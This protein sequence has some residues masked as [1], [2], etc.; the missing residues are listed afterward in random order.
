VCCLL[1]G[2][3]CVEFWLDF[4]WVVVILGFTTSLSLSC[5]TVLLDLFAGKTLDS[6][7]IGPLFAGRKI[8]WLDCILVV[9]LVMETWYA[10]TSWYQ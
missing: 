8:L 6:L 2:C 10:G 1:D 5:A 4:C 7:L 3:A 9:S